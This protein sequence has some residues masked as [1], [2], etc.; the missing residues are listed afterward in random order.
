MILEHLPKSRRNM[1][2]NP[3]WQKPEIKSYLHQISLDCIKKLVDCIEQFN[4][5]DISTETYVELSFKVD[6]PFHQKLIQFR[7]V[8]FIKRQIIEK[9]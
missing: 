9:I 3:G 8:H 4:N 1:I 7:S 6:L 2:N 5:G